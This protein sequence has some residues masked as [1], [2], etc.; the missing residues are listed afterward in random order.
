[1]SDRTDLLQAGRGADSSGFSGGGGDS[2]GGT[3]GRKTGFA[4][5]GSSIALQFLH[6]DAYLK[7][8]TAL[9][10]TILQSVL[11]YADEVTP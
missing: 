10:L 3:R 4:L 2:G 6:A 5:P 8:V 1:M 11:L 7:T 9:R